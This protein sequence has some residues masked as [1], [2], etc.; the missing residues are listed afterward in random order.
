MR[1]TL[2]FPQRECLRRRLESARN[3]FIVKRLSARFRGSRRQ[4]EIADSD[5]LE[6]PELAVLAIY[7]LR[8][9]MQP[10]NAR[11]ATTTDARVVEET[12]TARRPGDAQG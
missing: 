12:R 9:T 3:S 5:A 2:A 10:Q 1:Q 6:V 4:R 8:L 7:Q 11:M